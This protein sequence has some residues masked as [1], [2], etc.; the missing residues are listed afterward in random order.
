MGL[1]KAALQFIAREHRRK[2]FT[3]AVLTLGRQGVLAT[4]EDVCQMLISERITPA[5][6]S[7]GED[8]RTNIPDWIGTPYE[9]NT[10]DV[11]FFKLLGLTD[12]KAL[13]YSEYENAEI[14]HDLNLPVLNE[15]RDRFDLIVD[16]GTTE[17][18]FDVRQSLTNIAHML[19]PGG[20]VIHISPANNYTNHGFYQF[21]PTLYFDYYS[22]NAFVDLRGFIAEQDTYLYDVRPWDVFEATAATGRLTSAQSL[23]IIFVAEKTVRSTADVIPVQTFYQ[24]IYQPSI[25]QRFSVT[26][27]LK[28]LLP[29]KVKVFLARNLPFLDPLRKPWGL[30]RWGRLG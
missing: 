23:M 8:T 19:K 16:A 6:L 29:Y 11:V 7:S 15:L 13:D 25:S 26:A 10:S 27:V 17:H 21:S 9:K 1:A 4:L 14:I 28:H 18:V 24:Q 12:I 2:P 3:G 22:A 30:K 20:R 5:V